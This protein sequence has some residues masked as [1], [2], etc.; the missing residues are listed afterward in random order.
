[1]NDLASDIYYLLIAADSP[2]L[3][4]EKLIRLLT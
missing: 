1:M 2:Q 3:V 4:M